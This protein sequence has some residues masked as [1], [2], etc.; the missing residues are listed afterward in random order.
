M[1]S[2]SHLKN[3]LIAVHRLAHKHGASF[4]YSYYDEVFLMTI[5]PT[6]ER[7]KP[8]KIKRKHKPR[9]E[10]MIY[11]KNC[12]NCNSIVVSGVC[13]KKDCVYNLNKKSKVMPLDARPN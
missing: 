6:G 7:I 5:E 11:I 1:I 13:M 4:T 10:A 3:N 12:P 9:P 2:L 8:Q